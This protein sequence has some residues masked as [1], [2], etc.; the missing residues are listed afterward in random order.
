MNALLESF[1]DN[2]DL[3]RW[4]LRTIIIVMLLGFAVLLSI[5][6]LSYRN[7]PPIPGKVVNAQGVTLFTGADISDGQTVFLKYGLMDNG[8]IWGHGAYLGP[9]YS[10]DALHR[11]G[12]DTANALAIAHV[13]VPFDQLDATQ[14][15][16]IQAQTAVTLK[17]NR[18]DAATDTLT[19]TAAE[20]L[21]WQQQQGYWAEYFKHPANNGGLKPN[22]ITD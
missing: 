1:E 7:A 12:I 22:L 18:Y 17:Q 14:Q 5:T 16:G 9:D 4:W 2:G 3:S 8:S 10:A 11:M 21:A 6:V 20:T 15:A 13:G 19:L